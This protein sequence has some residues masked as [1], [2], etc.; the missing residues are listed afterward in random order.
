MH[1]NVRAQ[2]L[3]AHCHIAEPVNKGSQGLSR[4]LADA[5]QG[6]GCQVARPAGGVG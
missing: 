1:G 5:H 3:D 6:D 2:L 4:L